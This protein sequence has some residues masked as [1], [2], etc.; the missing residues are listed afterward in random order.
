MLPL[1]V[2]RST[3][4]VAAVLAWTLSCTAKGNQRKAELLRP[5]PCKEVERL[6]RCHALQELRKHHKV[7]VIDLERQN[8]QLR[9]TCA[10][11]ALLKRLERCHLQQEDDQLGNDSYLCCR[12]YW[13]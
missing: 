10:S 4:V 11:T 12:P 6:P 9:H 5:R 13:T 2:R 8:I 7:S 1:M 3:R